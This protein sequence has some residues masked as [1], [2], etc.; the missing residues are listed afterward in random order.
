[1]LKE[2]KYALSNAHGKYVIKTGNSYIGNGSQK[3]AELWDSPEQIKKD[4]T[5]RT[6]SEEFLKDYDIIVTVRVDF[7]FIKS[8]VYLL[9][10]QFGTMIVLENQN[11]E[12]VGV[13]KED[14][15][16]KILL[17]YFDK[18]GEREVKVVKDKEPKLYN[19]LD[20]IWNELNNQF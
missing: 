11:G 16:Y 2:T 20:V 15:Y 4:L 8:N 19:I 5:N 18:Y 1:M 13:D 10:R 14:N 7:N 9:Y 17:C 3:E 6:C 12:K